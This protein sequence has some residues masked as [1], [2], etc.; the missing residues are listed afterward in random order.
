MPRVWIQRYNRY[1]HTNTM[2]LMK[3]EILKLCKLYQGEP[4]NP[5]KP[6]DLSGDLWAEEYLKFQIWDAEYAV[7]QNFTWWHDQWKENRFIPGL[8]KSDTAEEVYKL[9]IFDKLEKMKRPDIDF[10]Q[11]Y[12]DL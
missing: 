1:R 5:Y 4:N 11:M 6:G 2:G 7:T 9:A 12:F 3:D 10:M 8:S